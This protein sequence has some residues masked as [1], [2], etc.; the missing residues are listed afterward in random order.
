MLN[1][2]WAGMILLGVIYGVCTGQMSALTGGALDS[3]REAVSLCI[4]MAGVM[5]LWMGLMEI[6]QESGMI[7]KMTKGIRP[8]LKFMFPRLPEDHPAGEYITTNL[9]A[10]VLGLGWACTP[11]GLKAMEQLA[12]LEKQRA[13][14]GTEKGRQGSEDRRYGAEATAA[15]NEMCTF[16][17]LN[18]SS[19]QLIPVN[20][21]AYRS[22]Y[23]SANPAVIIAPALVATLFSTI[24]AIIY[25]KWKDR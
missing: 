6:A 5:A 19:L 9:I 20:M 14:Q 2:I 24:I 10:N 13:G 3:A 7:A 16:L 8:F 18:I 4:T 21:I 23:G 17:I 12:E 1:Y 11:A 22:Q 25:C 15:S